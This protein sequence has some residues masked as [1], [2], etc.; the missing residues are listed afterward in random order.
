MLDVFLN[1]VVNIYGKRDLFIAFPKCVIEYEPVFTHAWYIQIVDALILL[2]STE[3][4]GVV[5]S[6][7]LKSDFAVLAVRNIESSSDESGLRNLLEEY[8]CLPFFQLEC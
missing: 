1:V 3:D 2:V 5:W 6:L 7:Y 4:L 8:F